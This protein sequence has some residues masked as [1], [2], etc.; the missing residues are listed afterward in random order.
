MEQE[1]I[2][3][4]HYKAKIP[5]TLSYPIGAKAISEAL[6]GVPQFDQ[7]SV[8]FS[9]DYEFERSHW[10]ATR[11]DVMEAWFQGSQRFLSMSRSGSEQ[12]YEITVN[13]VPRS[14]RHL[15]Q[16]KIVNEALPS[17]RS[18]LLA[19]PHS[20]ELGEAAHGLRFSFDELKSELTREEFRSSE[21]RVDTHPGRRKQAGRIDRP[22]IIEKEP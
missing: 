3:P 13:A 15:I 17:V 20:V 18:W 19:N 5:H 14:L 22:G 16:S 10:R 9:V 11:Y 12:A 7:L 21:P 8:H 1:R 2:I 4:T 6:T